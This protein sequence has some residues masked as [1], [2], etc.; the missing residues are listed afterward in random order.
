MQGFYDPV[1]Q[2]VKTLNVSRKGVKAGEKK[3]LDPEVVYA[4]AL[5][6]RCI[7]S[8]FHFDFESILSHELAPFPTSMFEEEGLLRICR[9]KSKLMNSLKVAASARLSTSNPTAVFVDG[10]A[11]FWT[12][13][14]PVKG[15]VKDYVCNFLSYILQRA[16][17]SNVYLLFDRYN[18]DS[19]KGF[20]LQ[21]AIW[22][23]SLV[24]NPPAVNV[25]EGYQ[26]ILPAPF[27]CSIRNQ[28]SSR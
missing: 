5:A 25:L 6:L 8:D 9:Q 28:I 20:H 16:K 7:D 18:S 24:E 10:C 23:N 26:C 22:R 14:W 1:K 21:A 27:N 2:T 11:I 15:K 3:I 12:V 13:S 17:L 4:R 19:I